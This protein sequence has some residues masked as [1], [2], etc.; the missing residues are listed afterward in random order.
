[1]KSITSKLTVLL[2]VAVTLASFSVALIAGLNFRNQ[3][4]EEADRQTELVVSSQSAFI[5]DWIKTRK[6]MIEAGLTHANEEATTY[7]LEQLAKGGGFTQLFVGDGDTKGMVYSIPGKQ[8]PSPDYDPN[9]RGWFKKASETGGT[10]VTEPYKAASAD[11]KDLVITLAHKVDGKNKVLGGDIQIGHL[12][13]SV[14]SVKLPGKGHAFLMTREGKIIAYPKPGNELKPITELIPA[15][16]ADKIKAQ[17]QSHAPTQ[18]TIDGEDFL[19]ELSTVEGTDWLL[20]VAVDKSEV[21]APLYR[22]LWV[23]TGAVAGVLVVLTL[24]ST[25]Y[26]RRLL[27]GLLRVRD[28]M[29]EISQGEG[30]LTRRI[31]V[32]G[33]DEVAETAAAFNSFVERLN[34]MFRELRGE[35]VQLAEGVIE[36]GGAVDRLAADSNR[37]ADISSSNAAAIEEV[38]VS[39]SYIADAARSTDELARETG[40][41]SQGSAR[42]MMRINDEMSRTSDSVGELSG[43]L[44][45]LEKRSQEI[46]QIASVISDIADQTNL[47]ALNAAIEA[48]RAGE[49]GRGFAVVADEVRKLAERTG[50]ATVEITGMIETI[51]NEIGR[52]VDNMDQ[53]VETVGVGVALTQSAR[54]HLDKISGTMN[55]VV[56]NISAIAHSTSE[57]HNATT[58]MAQSTESINNQIMDSDA[59]LQVARETLVTLNELAR[60]MQSAFGRFKL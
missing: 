45:S 42:D 4:Y 17:S 55:Q 36:V 56:E 53:T 34:G 31:Q 9:V 12:A 37:L 28:A 60:S 46:S 57:Q 58:A 35:A 43:L 44:G 48:A 22:M 2:G 27:Q 54:E 3:A 16:D 23:I 13:Q 24:L 18:M 32:A 49:Q 39:I 10:I 52:A 30:D 21:D 59:S 41:A 40:E 5:S 29:K 25:A 47:L 20:G 50:K 8:K 15:L 1:M 6:S 11:I 7:Y 33:Q 26:L 51:L 38:T 14:L 19:V